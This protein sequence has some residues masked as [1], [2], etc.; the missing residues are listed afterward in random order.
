MKHDISVPPGSIDEFLKVADEQ[1]YELLE[2]VRINAFGH[3]GDGNIHYNL[4]PPKGQKGFSNQENEISF[5]IARSA[6]NMRGS[7]AAEHGLGRSKVTLA[8]SLRS[9]IERGLMVR[10]KNT[11]DQKKS[12]N[13]GV[14]VSEKGND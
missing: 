9:P 8:D 11:F 4:S 5:N 3:L 6:H 2:G 1:C 7:I 10:V 13:P 14:I 12:L